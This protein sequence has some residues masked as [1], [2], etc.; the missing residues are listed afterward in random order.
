MRDKT[1]AVL[2]QDRGSVLIL[3]LQIEVQ[4]EEMPAF[5]LAQAVTSLVART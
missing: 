3:G 5:I 1:S 4:A 2:A